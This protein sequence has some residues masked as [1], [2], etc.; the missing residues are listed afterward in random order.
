MSDKILGG[1]GLRRI[2]LGNEAVARGAIEAGI[3]LATGY[4]GTPSTEIVETLI[5]V[6]EKVGFYADWSVNEKVAF[7]TAYAAA[8]SGV[9]SIVAMK[10]VGLNVAADALFS[11]AYA[12]AK[13]G[14]VVVSAD[15]PQMWSSQNEQDNRFYGP[16]S[17]VPVFEPSDPGEAKELTRKLFD[18]SERFGIPVILRMTTR[19]S[20]TW[21]PV[22][23]GTLRKPDLSG[24]FEKNPSRWTLVPQNARRRRKDLL[25]RISRLED[26]VEKYEYNT[27]TGEGRD[28]L[29]IASGTS[30]AYAVDAVDYLDILDKVTILKLSSIYPMPRKLV[31]RSMSDFR[32][33]LVVEELEP[34][35]ETQ[36]KAIAYEEGLDIEV[37]GKNV[38]PR[39]GELDY[40]KV[41]EA[42]RRV[43]GEEAQSSGDSFLTN[44]YKE[45]RNILPPRPPVLCPGCP[46]RSV[47]Y[48]LRKAV[49]KLRLKPVY[50]GDIG[51]YSLGLLKP[52][53]VQDILL[54]M[55]SSV[56]IANGLA[57]VLSDNFIISIL[58]DS[59]FFHAA[60]PGIIN[61]AY[62]SAPVLILIL[63]NHVTAMTGHQ[64][65]PG[66]KF[67]KDR[68]VL[69]IK[70]VLEGLGIEVVNVADA[71][72]PREVENVLLNTMKYIEENKKPAAVI[73]DGPCMLLLYSSAVKKG[74]KPPLYTVNEDKCTGCSACINLLACPA[75]RVING[76]AR[77]D[78]GLCTGCG[79]CT[80]VCPFDAIIPVRQ[81]DKI[82]QEERRRI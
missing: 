74:G 52:F 80:D 43:W 30:Y 53:E 5:K 14:F 12:G 61:I 68:K 59:T 63:S 45:A 47:F 1:P 18:I 70:K 51:C 25:Q 28:L 34:F 6:S 11:S 22:L 15:D 16:H 44:I 62:T 37:F 35:L 24:F 41:A 33:V 10:H 39:I 8:M 57:K 20:H 29:I 73:A 17:L 66:S 48:A 67:L 71:F 27:L 26:F 46:Y 77:I 7:E 64:P 79:V 23:F 42:I 21:G 65:H 54:E 3:G 78:P 49:N 31:A 4:P 36:V 32:K 2:L 58:G 50:S 75:I 60:L 9:R 13:A 69:D 19:I 56:G 40:E 81:G 38:L 82:W 55:G 76:K 72:K